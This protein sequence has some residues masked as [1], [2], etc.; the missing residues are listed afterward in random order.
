MI[1]LLCSCGGKSTES[2]GPESVDMGC[3]Q[4]IIARYAGLN[5][6]INDGSS[7]KE[8]T[9][10]DESGKDLEFNSLT[11]VINY[12]TYQGW[13]LE[14]VV[15]ESQYNL[16]SQDANLIFSRPVTKSRLKEAVDKGYCN[17]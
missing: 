16:Y 8:V 10:K 13:S 2:Y 12:M 7:R 4:Y 1:L 9:L 6:K 14:N 15:A 11:S 17:R 5:I 3:K